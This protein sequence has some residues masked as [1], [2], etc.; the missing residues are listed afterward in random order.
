ML[1]SNWIKII[2]VFIFLSC[3]FALTHSVQAATSR[4]TATNE[5]ISTYGTTCGG[6]CDYTVLATWEEATDIDLVAATQSEVLECYDDAASFDDNDILDGAI[7][8]SSYFRIIRPASG[9]GHDGT[10]N[11]GFTFIN[12][13][14]IEIIGISENYSQIQDLI[15]KLN[16]N[17]ASNKFT[18]TML[19]DQNAI[20]GCIVFD[21]VNASATNVA[22][23]IRSAIAD[24]KVQYII[25]CLAHNCEQDG[26]GLSNTGTAYFYNCTST[27][28]GRYG[29]Y[30]ANGTANATNCD[31]NN[32]S[33]A[34]RYSLN[35]ILMHHI[36]PEAP[37][38]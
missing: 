20:I 15:G 11:N 31:S 16:I 13:T 26:F 18:F 7:T 12:T 24:P 25:N 1:K 9:Q 30:R 33:L 37:H 17:I 22:H 14:G 34:K 32:N 19:G 8:D 29:F 5:H 3:F 28:N 38:N 2:I 6:T 23:G 10:P 4:R 36:L 35:S 21:S 27:N